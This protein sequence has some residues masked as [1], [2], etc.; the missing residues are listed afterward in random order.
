MAL[1]PYSFENQSLSA[2]VWTRGKVTRYSGDGV[3]CI[4]CRVGAREQALTEISVYPAG[5][6]LLF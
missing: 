6:E 5:F 2:A 4:W 1:V 3:S